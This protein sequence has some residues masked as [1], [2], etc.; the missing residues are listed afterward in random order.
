MNYQY[1]SFRKF[2]ASLVICFELPSSSLLHDS[3]LLP[4][5]GLQVLLA[6]LRNRHQGKFPFS[7]ISPT[8]TLQISLEAHQMREQPACIAQRAWPTWSHAACHPYP[9]HLVSSTIS[10]HLEGDA[11]CKAG[12]EIWCWLLFVSPAALFVSICESPWYRISWYRPP[13]CHHHI[14]QFPIFFDCPF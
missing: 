6:F 7:S 4:S 13:R 14:S 5:W 11:S 2:I 12:S 8:L 10:S 1:V 9:P 3:F